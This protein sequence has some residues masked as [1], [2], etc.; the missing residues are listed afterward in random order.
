M[1]PVSCAWTGREHPTA[2]PPSTP[3]NS[4]R[5]MPTPKDRQCTKYVWRTPMSHMGQSRPNW[6]ARAMSGLPPFATKLRT[7]AEVR[8][9][10]I[11]LQKSKIRRRQK[12]RESR[13][14]D[15]T[16]AARLRGADTKVCGRFGV[17]RYSPSH[18]EARDA[19]AALKI[20]VHHP[21]NTFA[22]KS[23]TSRLMQRSILA[24]YSI[25]SSARVTIRPVSGRRFNPARRR[26]FQGRQEGMSL[27]S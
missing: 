7:S 5:R 3:R 17:K 10:P 11:L 26:A 1:R 16:V 20:S 23:A 12:S 13:S 9:V 6:A 2:A 27:L 25:S 8:F 21:Q 24:R 14:R 15:I 18:R 4:R 22:T 19:S